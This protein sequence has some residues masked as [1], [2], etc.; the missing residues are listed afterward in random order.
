MNNEI[1]EILDFSKGQLISFLRFSAGLS[2]PNFGGIVGGKYNLRLQQNPE[3]YAELLFFF[4]NLKNDT[5]LELGIG[6]GGSFFLNSLFQKNSKLFNAV[7]NCDYQSHHA[8]FSD[9]RT[10]IKKYINYLNGFKNDSE[11][12]FFDMKT[13][14][15]FLTNKNIYDVIFI[16]ADHNYEG[17]KEDYE[18]S[19]KFLSKEGY[20]IFHDIINEGCGVKQLW[21]E[22]DSNKKINEF[23][24][25]R[26]CGIGIYKP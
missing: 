13:K 3:E 12:N 7:D 11:V 21:S 22:L 14:D 4:K 16:D 25:S 9:Q 26:D 8:N 24:Y 20:L 1:L 19:L 23:I 10:S 17:V 15:F 5:Y 18:N 2:N 6:Q